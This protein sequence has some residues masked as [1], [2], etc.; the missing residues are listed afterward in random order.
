VE[1]RR[2]NR[3]FWEKYEELGLEN[4][5]Q[6]RSSPK[7]SNLW[8]KTIKNS[9]N[10]DIKIR[11]NFGAIFWIFNIYGGNHKTRVNMLQPKAL[12]PYDTGL[13]PRVWSNLYGFTR[14]VAREED[15]HE[16]HDEHDEHDTQIEGKPTHKIHTGC[17]CWPDSPT[18]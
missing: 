16:E 2:E 5:W 17:P 13:T 9:T 4:L 6:Y 18:Q 1:I 12:I 14:F 7:T 3:R 11:G 15:E 8:I 10:Q